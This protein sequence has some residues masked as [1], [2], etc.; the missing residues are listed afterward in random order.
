MLSI[1]KSSGPHLLGEPQPNLD[2]GKGRRLMPTVAL[3]VPTGGDKVDPVPSVPLQ[4]R[5]KWVGRKVPP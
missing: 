5:T 4:S 2:E 3:F 1:D